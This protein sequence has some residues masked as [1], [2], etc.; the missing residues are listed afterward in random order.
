MSVPEKRGVRCCRRRFLS[1]GLGGLAASAGV[2]YWLSRSPIRLGL[3]G[4]GH[5]GRYLVRMAQRLWWQGSYY[6]RIVAL[7][8]VDAHHARIVQA[9]LC[10]EA[11]TYGDYRRL[12][13]RDDVEAVIIATPDHWH[14]LTAIHALQAGKAVYCEKP[15]GLTIAEGQ[16]LVRA[17]RETDGLFLG[18]TMQRSDTR[19]RAA[20][21]L[22]RNGRL[23]NVRRVHVILPRR[24]QG[25]SSGPFPITAPPPELDWE[26]WLGQAP[27]AGYSKERCHGSFRRWYE[28]S[29]GQMT[30]WGAHHIDIVHW[31]FGPGARPLTIA[32]RADMPHI[33]NGYNTPIEFQ[34]DVVFT[35]G[36]SLHVTTD[37]DERHTGIRFEGDLGWLFVTRGRLEG[38][39]VEEAA[40]HPLLENA[41]HLADNSRPFGVMSSNHLLHFF[42]CI[43]EGETPIADVVSQHRSSTTCHLAN[44]AMRLGRK[45]TWNADTEEFAN[46]AE[47]NAMRARPRRS[48]YELPL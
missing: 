19:F 16:R 15:L 5:Q 14:A 17:V 41:E 39:A 37:P 22:V 25:E 36:A 31:A 4:A 35:N 30:D 48:G 26:A 43:R 20:C 2:G 3:I 33:A 6:G 12:L 21:E 23:G 34:A 24:W 7:A 13:E 10:P 28:Y 1:I 9:E 40:R 42:R 44:I 18:G 29:G 46:D 45:L 47:A 38:S 27:L 32:G 8:D 11:E